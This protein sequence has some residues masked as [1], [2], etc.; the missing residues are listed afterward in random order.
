MQPAITPQSGRSSA[1]A[2]VVPGMAQAIIALD[3]AVMF[4]ALPVIT[5]QL[6]LSTAEAGGI[7][8]VYGL[9]FAA[10]LLAGGAICDRMGARLTFSMAM[11][12]FMLASV[13]GAL[14]HQPEWLLAA[15]ALQGVAAAFMQPSILA[16]MAGRFQG[17][18]YRQALTIWSATGA[19]GLVAGVILG[20]ILAQLYWPLIFLLNIPAGMLI[21]WLVWR[22]FPA[23]PRSE[24]RGLFTPG[25]LVGSAAAGC[26]VLALL[27]LSSEGAP[28]YL[29]NRL[30]VVLAGLFLLHEKW[31]SRPLI[32]PELRQRVSFQ[33][34]W[35]ASACYMA[36]AGSQFYLLTLLWQQYYDFSALQTGLLFV[37]LAVL[38]MGGNRVYRRLAGRY[39]MQQLLCLGFLLCA[40]GFYLQ[41]SQALTQQSL[42]FVSGVIL[43]GIGHGIVYPAIFS[44][45]LS[46]VATDLQG[47]A[48]AVIVTSQYLS[49]AITLAVL[50]LLLGKGHSASEW[51]QAFQWLTWAAV[52]GMV[53]AIN[54]GKM[55]KAGEHSADS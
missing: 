28:D 3:Y 54:A 26:T 37:P 25:A 31:S 52:A 9:C 1:F 16:L 36:S 53:V 55:V 34:S 39:S 46:G 17:T 51:E 45:G 4:V 23:Q 6:H 22:H 50:G 32:G 18:A 13:P 47:R 43:S 10:F 15:R 30:A 40:A 24:T 41:G 29:L 49:G 5:A 12:L 11:G 35:L 42:W 33:A 48:S 2:S 21:L 38:I 44:L 19:A 14:A 27:R 8:A 20:G 7:M